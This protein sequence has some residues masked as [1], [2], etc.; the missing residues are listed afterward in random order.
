M[1]NHAPKIVYRFGDN[2]YLNITNRCPN[3]CVF[4]IKTKWKMD[5]H[6]NN[7][8]LAGDEPTAQ[9]VLRVLEDELKQAPFKEVVFCGYGEP[10][11]R[12]DVLLY[13]A[14]TL[15]GWQAQAKFP[16]FKI[17][18]N[19]NG[20][21]NRI[22]HKC[23]VPDLRRVVD[24]INVSVNAENEEKWRQLL[25]PEAQYQDAY[26]DVLAFVEQCVAAG[27]EKVVLSCVEHTGADTKALQAL[28]N[29]YGAQ[30]YMR[31]FLDENN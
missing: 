17:R 27:F 4:C 24:L 23:I 9:E 11:M 25:R 3:L 7:L 26:P 2:V 22:N 13:V 10:T 20:L 6:G 16:P 5:F 1:P 31:S 21:G 30:F 28:A 14:Q 15:K 18:L 12:L 8:N 29:T 19:T